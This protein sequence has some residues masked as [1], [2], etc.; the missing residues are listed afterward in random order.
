M[1]T[2]IKA[3]PPFLRISA[4]SYEGSLFGWD[5]LE[6]SFDNEDSTQEAPLSLESKMVYG[7][8]CT[9]Q[10]LRTICVSKS[11]KFLGCGGMDER[12]KIFSAKENKSL[13]ELTQHSGAIT[14]LEF[15]EDSYLLSGSEDH[16]ICI[17]RLQ[18]WACV[19]ILG[20]HKDIVNSISIHPSGK[21]ALSVSKDRTVKI[22]NL[23][24]G[25]CAFTRRLKGAADKI[26]WN[27][28]GDIYLIVI[29]HEI[30]LY[31]AADNSLVSSISFASR[32]NQVVFTNVSAGSSEDGVRL[33]TISEDKLCR[34]YKPTGEMTSSL[35]LSAFD[36]GRPRD[37]VSC[38]PQPGTKLVNEEMNQILETEGDFLIIITSTGKVAVLSSTCIDSG[39]A[40]VESALLVSDSIRVEPR[41]TC[42]AAWGPPGPVS[43]TGTVGSTSTVGAEGKVSKKRK[44]GAVSNS[45]S[46]STIMDAGVAGTVKDLDVDEEMELGVT[47]EAAAGKKNK[48]KKRK[49][50]KKSAAVL[51]SLDEE[52]AV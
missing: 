48:N 23:V 33:A 44:A 19:H 14:C 12:I 18:D 3:H 45:T 32:I 5:I 31:K 26:L 52:E 13:G 50:K 34:L 51:A 37:L 42:C 30:Q 36:T 2:P 20:G 11:G 15:F 39:D 10:S 6:S 29:N 8:S 7:F 25:T 4:C 27:K 38:R 40:S 16:T 49:S 35:D 21:L 1:T 9:S 22:W 24:Q 43:S 17:W 47:G 41:L 28:A 46:T